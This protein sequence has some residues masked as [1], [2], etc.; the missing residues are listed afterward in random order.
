M[1]LFGH[2]LRCCHEQ[3]SSCGKV[4]YTG[5]TMKS[6]LWAITATIVGLSATSRGY[7]LEGQSWPVGTVVVLQLSLGN[8]GRT[9]QDGNT[10]WNDA[11]APVAAM[12]NQEVQRVQLTQ[13]LNPGAP[14]AS[15]DH[16]NSVVFANSVFGQQFGGN[17]LAVTYYRS[18]GSTM[19]EADI[20]F[21]R[22]QTF[23]SYR[24][25]LQ[26]PPHGFAIAD[27]RRVFLHELG[28]TLG[29]GHP[30]TAGQHVTA[31]MNSIISNQEVLSADDFAGG[32][33]IYG[34]PPAVTPTPTA[35]PGSSPSHLANISTR[36]KVGL[37]DNV[38]IGGF[39][40]NGAQPKRVI[41]RAI[42][43]SLAASGVANALAD[44]VLELHDSSGVIGLNDD[45]QGGSQ[46]VDI[47]ASGLAPSDP[48]ESA[49]IATLSPGNYTAV[50]SGSLNGQGVGLVDAYEL[51]ANGT[52][53]VNI[54][55]RGQVGSLDEVM[56]GGFIVEGGNAKRVIVRALG[57]SLATGPNP[58]AGA[59]ADPVLE[60]RD[61]SGALIALNDNWISSPQYAEIVASTLAPPNIMESA[62]IAT[63]GPG[64]YTA[65]VR[66]V[67][68]TSGVG[69][70]EV[71]DL[72]P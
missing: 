25:P 16:L 48:R 44:P 30:D 37:G 40:I 52:R 61:G 49:I 14:A 46:A 24:G 60:L 20:L 17:T 38:L 27:I 54:S 33:S 71:Y 29:L 18:S 22:A 69:L 62:I 63:C 67:N 15:G 2:C 64:N 41:V 47:A 65:I 26:F 45:W 56:I 34:A 55:T 42:G 23:D 32:Q 43:P 66:G 8:A 70:V 19:S 72:D 12:W 21:N 1:S 59:L 58:V 11:V 53:L 4:R 28:H 10:S 3:L 5:R 57:P 51:G 7:I 35:T 13:I 9:L 39:I 6:A 50:V 68:N 31:V 36:I